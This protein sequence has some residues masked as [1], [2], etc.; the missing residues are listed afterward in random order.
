MKKTIL[1][2][3]VILISITAGAQEKADPII[4]RSLIFDIVN[5]CAVVLMT[6][7]ITSFVLQMIK[8]NF[9]YRLKNKVIEKQ[10]PENIT[11]HLLQQ[12]TKKDNRNTILQWIFVMAGIGTGTAIVNFSRPYGLHSVSIMAFSIATGLLGYYLFS[13]QAEK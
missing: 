9:D 10:T 5:I 1:L 13:R 7:L 6:Y 4:D 8:Q 12:T 3:S 11:G 2:L